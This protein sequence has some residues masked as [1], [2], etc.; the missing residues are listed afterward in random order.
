MSITCQILK[1]ENNMAVTLDELK[2]MWAI[3][4]PYEELLLY[5]YEEDYNDDTDETI[6][7]K[8]YRKVLNINSLK[9]KPTYGKPYLMGHNHLRYY[10]AMLAPKGKTDKM[11]KV[12]DSK[13]PSTKSNYVGVEIEFISLL[14]LK[15]VQ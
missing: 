5:K 2:D 6:E 3:K 4:R 7:V 9:V 11:A 10:H 14:L 1:R 15:S 12:A 8:T 13:V